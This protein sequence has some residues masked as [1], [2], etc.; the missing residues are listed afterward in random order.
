VGGAQ[1]WQ[2]PGMAQDPSAPH[3]ID[4]YVGSRLRAE[5]MAKGWSQQALAR[6]LN[7]SF[8]QVQKYERGI[9]RIS[10][11]VI[12]TACEALGIEASDLFP[13]TKSS[14]RPLPVQIDAYPGG[15]EL[16]RLYAEMSAPRRRLLLATATALVGA[17]EVS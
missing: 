5:R 1:R 14:E 9:N 12:M 2:K 7:L 13:Q 11:S 4:V 3:P 10:A 8:Q 17:D 15:A 16:S 6:S